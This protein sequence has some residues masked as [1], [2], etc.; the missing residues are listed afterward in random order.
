MLV[1]VENWNEYRKGHS[2]I[3]TLTDH[4]V[5]KNSLLNMANLCSLLNRRSRDMACL[6]CKFKNNICPKYIADLFQR[7][8]TKYPLRNK[9]FVIPRFNNTITHGKHS[10]RYNGSKL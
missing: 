5:M 3:F 1:T 8:D 10:I 7:T 9:E 6:M 4:Q 2:E